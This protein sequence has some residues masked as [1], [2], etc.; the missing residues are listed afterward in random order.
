MTIKNYPD[1]LLHDI[2]GIEWEYPRPDDFDGLPLIIHF[3]NKIEPKI[4]YSKSRKFFFKKFSFLKY[5]NEGIMM[6]DEV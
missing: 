3:T 2:I 4:Y 1:N 5:A 6:L